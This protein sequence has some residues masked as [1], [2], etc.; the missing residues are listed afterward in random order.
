MVVS[1]GGSRGTATGE[2]A[3]AGTVGGDERAMGRERGASG[4]GGRQRA[5]PSP[6]RCAAWGRSFLL[7]LLPFPADAVG[8][9]ATAGSRGRSGTSSATAS[10]SESSPDSA[11]DDSGLSS[12]RSALRLTGASA[13]SLSRSRSVRLHTD[14][15]GCQRYNS[16]GG[17]QAQG[18]A[19]SGGA[20]EQGTGERER[21]MGGK[22]GRDGRKGRKRAKEGAREK[23]TLHRVFTNLAAS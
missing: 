13:A 18:W 16:E 7:A 14:Q 20:R 4:R 22:G 9:T 12:G 21:E 19:W 15:S 1:R 8:S 11:P 5:A 2:S 6:V 23:R 17:C 3:A 10:W